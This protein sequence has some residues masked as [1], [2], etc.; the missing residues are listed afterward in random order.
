MAVSWWLLVLPNLNP[1]FASV[2]V[3]TKNLTFF[4]LFF[5]SIYAEASSDTIRNSKTFLISVNVVKF[6][7]T[8]I[9]LS[10][11]LARQTLLQSIILLPDGV[12]TWLF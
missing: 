8:M 6:K 10:T 11:N 12:L 4:D 3:G 7:N 2:A 9:T 1:S 5:D